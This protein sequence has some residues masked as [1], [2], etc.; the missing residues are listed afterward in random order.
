MHKAIRFVGGPWH[1]RV[2]YVELAPQVDLVSKDGVAAGVTKYFQTAR[3][4]LAEY[5]TKAGTHY[6]Q[7]VHGS[8]IKDHT[9]AKCTYRERM[10]PWKINRRELEDRLRRAMQ[11][12]G[13]SSLAG[14]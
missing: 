12:T 4:H 1:N 11:C 7:Y 14:S 6:Y 13:G 2:E 8:L 10:R 3:Y 9:A 5:Q